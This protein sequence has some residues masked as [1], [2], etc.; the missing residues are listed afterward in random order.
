MRHPILY[1]K[2]ATDFFNLGLGV[3]TDAISCI[4]TEERN[5]SFELEMEYPISGALF[6]SLI[7]DRIIKADAGHALSSK[8]QLFRIKRIDK[9]SNS[10]AKIYAEHVSYLARELAFQPVFNVR[11]QDGFGVLNSWRNAIVGSNPFTVRSDITTTNNTNLTI[12]DYD[13]PRQVLGGIEGSILHRWGGE[14]RFD[15]YNISLLRQRGGDANTLIAYGRNL[16]DLNQEENITN[17]FTSIYPFA[18]FKNNNANTEEIVT[19][20]NFVVDSPH[21]NAY[22]NRRVLPIDFSSEFESDVRPTQARLRELAEAYIRGNQVGV[23]RVSISLSFVDIT[24]TLDNSGSHYEELNLCDTVPVYFEKLGIET[25]AKIVRIEWNVLLDQYEKLEIGES[26]PTLSDA[27]RDIER[28]IDNVNNNSNY[29]LN[30]ANGRNTVFFGPDEPKANRVGDLWYRPNGED[31][32]LWHWTGYAWKF[33]MTTAPDERILE[34]I[35]EVER[36]SEEAWKESQRALELAQEAFDKTE[37]LF[38]IEDPLTG[39]S[40]TITALALG[41][42][43]EVWGDTIDGGSRI[44]QLA[45]DIN[46]RVEKGDIVSQINL[47][48]ELIR[49]ES[50]RIHLAGESLIDNAVIRDAH[51][52]SLNATKIT[53]GTLNAAS[54]N[55]INL[56]AANITSG[57]INANRIAVN[58]VNANRISTGT[59]TGVTIESAGTLSGRATLSR[60]VNGRLDIHYNG[61]TNSIGMRLDQGTLRVMNGDLGSTSILMPPS[62]EVAGLTRI[63]NGAGTVIQ[64]VALIV[65]GNNNGRFVRLNSQGGLGSGYSR[66]HVECVNNSAGTTRIWNQSLQTR[67]STNGYGFDGDSSFTGVGDI[68]I[69][70]DKKLKLRTLATSNFTEDTQVQL[71][72]AIFNGEKGLLLGNKYPNPQGGLW[73]SESGTV[74]V[75]INKKLKI[76]G[77]DD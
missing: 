65:R 4:V 11:N 71:V 12:Q 7:N 41:L 2:T 63:H 13:N 24:Q 56:N 61:N 49:I 77:D 53:A 37:P 57:F 28:E 62:G 67:A 31:T 70:G 1:D 66:S 20:N 50:R 34:K 16:T 25:R 21:V 60:L 10:V 22:P 26:R 58:S 29:A 42:Q 14:Y 33:V 40:T 69:R 73:I 54:V 8:N 19:I 27:I 44:T 38:N 39:Q 17:T 35:E 15:N 18:I 30:A 68:E 75:L 76:L 72:S 51:I 74:G 32:E 55:V 45:T 64:G 3:L 46:L 43:T 9:T 48:P 6:H 59:L 47:S 5:G 36:D 52:H 23:P